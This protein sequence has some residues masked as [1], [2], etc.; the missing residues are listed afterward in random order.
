MTNIVVSVTETETVTMKDKINDTVSPTD[1]IERPWQTETVTET[2][3]VTRTVSETET[4]E[5][6]TVTKNVKVTLLF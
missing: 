1:K 5:E 3:R 6:D 4:V 2:E